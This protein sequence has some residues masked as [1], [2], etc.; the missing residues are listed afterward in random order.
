MTL[1]KLE[2][3]THGQLDLQG[4]PGI[5]EEVAAGYES[6]N[7]TITVEGDATTEELKAL[8]EYVK[9]TSPNYFNM[10]KPVQ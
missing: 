6:I 4:F 9:R 8:Q 3:E 7:Y 5:S 1:K 10:A 2:I